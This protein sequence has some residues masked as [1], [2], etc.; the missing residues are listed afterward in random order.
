MFNAGA[1]A[2]FRFMDLYPPA[3]ESVDIFLDE[4]GCTGTELRLEDCVAD[5]NTEDCLHFLQDVGVLCQP[6]EQ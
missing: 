1:Q 2:L 3:E 4:L 5:T 6:A